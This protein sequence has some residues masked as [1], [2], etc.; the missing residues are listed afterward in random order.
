MPDEPS[1][2]KDQLPA[3][4]EGQSRQKEEPANP[5]SGKTAELVSKPEP[6]DWQSCVNL[7]I[8]TVNK[9]IQIVA[10]VIA[11]IWTW[12]VFARTSAPGLESKLSMRSELS[13][14]DTADKDVCSAMFHVWAK[15]D[16]QRAFDV[17]GIRI[18]AY[19]LDLSR[20]PKPSESGDP[21]PLDSK[22]IETQGRALKVGDAGSYTADLGGHYS[23]GTQNDSETTFR[24]RKL[25]NRLVEFRADIDGEESSVLLPFASKQSFSNYTLYSDQLCG[26]NASSAKHTSP[27]TKSK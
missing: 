16:G 7:W 19:L 20:L 3:A 1:P 2:P 27:E 21:F 14:G 11:G 4:I 12:N 13:W 15:N 8:D 18:T 23:P 17:T 5:T 6:R 26:Q 10:V 25:S 24:F 22:F 9:F